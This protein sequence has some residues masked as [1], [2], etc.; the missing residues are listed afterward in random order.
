[1]DRFTTNTVGISTTSS[2]LKLTP[3]SNLTPG[4]MRSDGFRL[5][6][7]YTPGSHVPSLGMP[8]PLG[9]LGP[10]GVPDP[11]GPAA[12]SKDKDQTSSEPMIH[13]MTLACVPEGMS[14]FIGPRDFLIS[15]G[16][17]TTRPGREVPT[18]ITPQHFNH[19]ATQVAARFSSNMAVAPTELAMRGSISGM[20]YAGTSIGS[21]LG[22]RMTSERSAQQNIP[23]LY[24]LATIEDIEK[25]I[26]FLGFCVSSN[27][28]RPRGSY[29][30]PINFTYAAAGHTENVP[31]GWGRIDVCDRFGL[32]TIRLRQGKGR[33]CDPIDPTA[34]PAMQIVPYVSEY[35]HEPNFLAVDEKEIGN[36]LK[37][38][39]SNKTRM[40]CT[41]AF[42]RAKLPNFV[43]GF[44]WTDDYV[45]PTITSSFRDA[46]Y[47]EATLKNGSRV[48]VMRYVIRSG[49]N[50]YI[51]RVQRTKIS[52]P[53]PDAN[54]RHQMFTDRT[55]HAWLH[56]LCSMDVIIH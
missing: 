13:A 35:A 47:S 3:P 52:G 31:M 9:N 20:D 40:L 49:I 25:N 14:S 10:M 26:A 4:G 19:V 50:N 45:K 1:M 38:D 37:I 48:M 11:F 23:Q 22:K 39:H 29:R 42:G 53:I 7:N 44:T 32:V 43:P 41:R 55:G 12:T 56:G 46:T 8:K 17:G 34:T 2:Q 27:P 21:S 36:L 28:E 51:G 15:A 6:G 24:P 33:D 5:T 54:R 16:N 30:E 18:V